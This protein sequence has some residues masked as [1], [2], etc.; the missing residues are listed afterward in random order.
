MATSAARKLWT[1][2]RG[3][4]WHRFVAGAL[5]GAAGLGLTLLLRL[6]GIGVFL[7]EVATQFVVDRIPGSIESFFIESMGEGAKLLGLLTAFAVF[8]VIPGIY[9][10]FYRRIEALLT[11]RRGSKS[12]LPWKRP[13]TEPMRWAVIAVYTVVPALLALFVALPILGGGW[14]GAATSAGVAAAAFSQLLGSALYAS[15][16]DYF[17]VEVR[18][19]HPEGFRLTRRQFLISAALATA[20]AV[21]AVYGLDSIVS[22]PGRLSFASVQDMEANEITPVP[23]FYAVTKN[24]TDPV[25]DAASWSLA[26]DGLVST[27]ATYTASDLA[28]LPGADNKVTLECVSN[29]VGGD[30][31]GNAWWSGVSLAALLDR[32]GLSP[33]A[34][35]VEFTC[36]DGYTVAVPIARAR[37]SLL[38]LRMNGLP[39]NTTHG[40]PARIV[41]PGVYGMFSAK[42]VTRIT[43]VQGEVQGFW[44]QKGW[45]NRG[46][47]RTTAIIATPPDASVVGSR[48]DIGGVAFAGDRGISKVE[49]STDG[50]VT[51]TP[52]TLQP[53]LSGLAWVLW[54][55]A[56]TPASAGSKTIV[57]RATEGTGTPQES[58]P[59]PPF[60][61]GA[62]GY[63]SITLLVRG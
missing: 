45:T 53:P 38:A 37:E 40:Y 22:R 34:D 55:Y 51:W 14:A 52:A 27:P 63:D 1:R 44:Q 2:L 30:L 60:P 54:T 11:P 6:L 15:V 23:A 39:L 48:V 33:N 56:W 29:A 59:S 61:N 36:V 43:A 19:K 8:L 24:V 41:V 13:G 4:P 50:G 32:S 47:I 20:G 46:L 18:A 26:V 35:W 17:L 9:A 28:A 58:A 49:V 25:V 42:W 5:A 12:L 16:L 31:I 7:P 57:A 10:L 62:S 21:L 3:L